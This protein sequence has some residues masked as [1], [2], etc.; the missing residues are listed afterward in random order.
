MLMARL[1]RPL[2]ID[3]GTSP[4]KEDQIRRMAVSVSRRMTTLDAEKAPAGGLLRLA[5]AVHGS[6]N[7]DQA[8][9]APLAG[10]SDNKYNFAIGIPIADQP[11]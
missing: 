5:P 2:S 8:G 3:R 1:Y 7:T 9:A 6:S 4:K 10:G 11:E